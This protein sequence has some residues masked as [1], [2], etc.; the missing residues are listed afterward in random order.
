MLDGKAYGD[1]KLK[2]VV[3]YHAENSRALNGFLKYS[4]PVYWQSMKKGWMSGPIFTEWFNDQ[5]HC[6]L[7]AY[8]KA[9][10]IVFKIFLV[11]DSNPRY[12]PVIE[13]S[14]HIKAIFLPPEH[15]T[16]FT[17][18]RLRSYCYI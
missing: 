10:N 17:A 1:Y 9:K 7:K 15:D 13:T 12:P 3:I 11:L 5:L 8:C 2:P 18:N 4:L 16:T 6:K 14:K